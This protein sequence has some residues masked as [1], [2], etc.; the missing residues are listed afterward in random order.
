LEVFVERLTKKHGVEKWLDAAMG[1]LV[2]IGIHAVILLAGAL[3]IIEQLVAYDST[4][5]SGIACGLREP[6]VVLD[7]VEMPRDV[8]ERRGPTP[9]EPLRPGR[10]EDFVGSP[11]GSLLDV[12]EPAEEHLDG[13]WF[14]CKLD[15]NLPLPPNAARRLPNRERFATSNGVLVW[16]CGITCR[17]S[18]G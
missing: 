14:I 7:R 8:F 11:P 17:L 3:V 1:W 2:S 4:Y 13:P 18:A 16:R 6:S 12:H 5:G 9:E 15:M 10:I